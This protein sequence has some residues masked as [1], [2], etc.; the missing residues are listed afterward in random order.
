V[1]EQ[2]LNRH[3]FDIGITDRMMFASP[4][5]EEVPLMDLPRGYKFP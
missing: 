2:T 4:F 1:V 3:G 5:P